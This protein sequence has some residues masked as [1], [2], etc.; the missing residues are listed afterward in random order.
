MTVPCVAGLM[1][2][3]PPSGG[4]LRMDEC[5]LEDDVDVGTYEGK[6]GNKSVGQVPVLSMG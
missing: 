2:R 1:G 3:R 6:V 4:H 5:V